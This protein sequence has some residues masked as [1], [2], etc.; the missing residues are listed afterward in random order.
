MSHGDVWFKFDASPSDQ[1]SARGPLCVS[2]VF[3]QDAESILSL[4]EVPLMVRAVFFS[5]GLFIALWGGAFLVIDKLVL[6]TDDAPGQS[7]FRGLFGG[8]ASARKKVVDPPDWA[9]FSLMSVGT[10]TMLYAVA[11]PK[12]PG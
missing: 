9:A 3:A 8:V 7:G 12:K 6:S 5:L 11:L 4:V 1:K 2:S 10:V